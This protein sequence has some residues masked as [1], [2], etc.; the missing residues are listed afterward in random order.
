MVDGKRIYRTINYMVT[1][2]SPKRTFTNNIK[3]NEMCHTI[4]GN[5]NENNMTKMCK[6][7]HLL[8]KY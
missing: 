8:H 2:Y 3:T 1:L 5:K 6:I 7:I 4:N